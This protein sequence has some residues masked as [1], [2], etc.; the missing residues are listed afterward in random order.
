[1]AATQPSGLKMAHQLQSLG[2]VV[3]R[4]QSEIRITVN[5]IYG[6]HHAH[7]EFYDMVLRIHDKLSR[8]PIYYQLQ[9]NFRN[10]AEVFNSRLI[11]VL[12][13]ESRIQNCINSV[14]RIHSACTN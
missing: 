3:S 9:S 6:L 12:E 2:I 8:P 11:E 14:C 13:L 5:I 7:D 10:L 1:M 4:I